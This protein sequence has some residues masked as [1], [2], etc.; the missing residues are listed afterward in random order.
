MLKKQPMKTLPK[1][2]Y[3]KTQAELEPEEHIALT[4][5]CEPCDACGTS[6]IEGSPFPYRE[7]NM[8]G[9]CVALWK[10]LDRLI[11]REATWGEF[12]NPKL[13]MFSE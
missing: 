7:H 11:G 2:K 12:L 13:S 1:L 4:G 8:C 6:D 3:R 9:H 10:R 5:K